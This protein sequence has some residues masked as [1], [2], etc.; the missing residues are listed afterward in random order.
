M[1]SRRNTRTIGAG[2]IALTVLVGWRFIHTTI[3]RMPRP[4]TPSRAGTCRG[5][6]GKRLTRPSQTRYSTRT[7]PLFA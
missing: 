2:F 4:R 6:R 5:L 3:P 1:S 7:T